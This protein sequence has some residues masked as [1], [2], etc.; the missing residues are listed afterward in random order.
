MLV[1]GALT[2]IEN[3]IRD[4]V[5]LN[6]AESQRGRQL[7]LNGR[8]LS[9]AEGNIIGSGLG[10]LRNVEWRQIS[11][12][13]TLSDMWCFRGLARKPFGR[14]ELVYLNWC[15]LL[16]SSSLDLKVLLT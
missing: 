8:C 4:D 15:V 13:G 16:G 7:R 9:K 12:K 14:R 5:L 2:A 6:R 10:D 1:K 3:D 11:C